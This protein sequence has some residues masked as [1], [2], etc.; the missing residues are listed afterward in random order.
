MI[1][2][3]RTTD[4]L[5]EHLGLDPSS[6]GAIPARI[7][8]WYVVPPVG[9]MGIDPLGTLG[10]SRRGS[11]VLLLIFATVARLVLCR[12]GALVLGVTNN[13]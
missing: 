2:R 8:A 5:L 11:G 1:P 12:V 13:E 6:G 7:D 3:A 10:L 4:R 9:A